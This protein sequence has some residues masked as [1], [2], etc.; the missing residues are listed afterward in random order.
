MTIVYS[1]VCTSCQDTGM[2]MQDDEGN[3]EVLSCRCSKED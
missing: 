1:N 2:V 3:L